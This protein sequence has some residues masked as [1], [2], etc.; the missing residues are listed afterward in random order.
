MVLAQVSLEVAVKM[1]AGVQSSEGLTGAGGSA[2]KSSGVW[3]LAR[4]LSAFKHTGLSIELL[5]CP[6]GMASGFSLC[7]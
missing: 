2:P 7:M 6:Q 4:C 3:L 1:L 5:Q